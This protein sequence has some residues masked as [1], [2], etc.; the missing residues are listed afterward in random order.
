MEKK[1]KKKKRNE[2]SMMVESIF[3]T[4]TA[5]SVAYRAFIAVVENSI[6]ANLAWN[7]K[8]KIYLRRNC[9]EWYSVKRQIYL[10][11]CEINTKRI[12]VSI[13]YACEMCIR[14]LK[15]WMWIWLQRLYLT[16]PKKT[17][18][19]LLTRIKTDTT[20]WILTFK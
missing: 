9:D 12:F 3:E 1:K 7:S 4:R 11:K 14:Y 18:T 16:N 6:R 19:R 8:I 13:L 5:D 2:S 17:N 15:Q 20:R 10:Q